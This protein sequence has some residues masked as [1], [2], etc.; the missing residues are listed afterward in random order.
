MNEQF[1]DDT[2]KHKVNNPDGSRQSPDQLMG[3]VADEQLTAIFGVQN[4]ILVRF[5]RSILLLKISYIMQA[6]KSSFG[7]QIK[8]GVPICNCNFE[9]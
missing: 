7:I 4:E 8:K 2:S 9:I 6:L 5:F 3:G 1:K